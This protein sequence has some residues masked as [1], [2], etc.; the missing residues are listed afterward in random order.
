MKQEFFE[1]KEEQKEAMLDKI[2][3]PKKI[4]ENIK[5]QQ[6]INSDMLTNIF[7]KTQE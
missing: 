3:S 4:K 7:V 5:L 6:K 2:T 1:N